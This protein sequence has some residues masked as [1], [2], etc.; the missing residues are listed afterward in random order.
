M[1]VL[2]KGSLSFEDLDGHSFL[3][4]LIGGEDLRLLGWDIRSLGDDL[5]HDTSDSFNTEGEGSGI[6]DDNISNVTF[7][8]ADDSTLNGSTIADSLIR[9]NTSVWL[10]SIEELLD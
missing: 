10:F 1:V 3:I 9:I 8:S 4:V 6:N 5:A 7:L 2:G